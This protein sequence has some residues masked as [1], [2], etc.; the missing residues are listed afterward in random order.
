MANC[1]KPYYCNVAEAYPTDGSCDTQDYY[2][3]GWSTLALVQ[4]GTTITDPSDAV[5]MQ[6]LKDAGKL[7]IIRNIK[8]ALDEPSALTI[9]SVTSCGT[10]ITI[11]YDR[12][13]TFTDSKVSKEVVE[14]YN[15]TKKLTFGGALLVGCD[16]NTTYV[17][18]EV[19]L[20]AAT[21]GENSNAAA[22]VITAVIGWRND[23]DPVP[24]ETPADIFD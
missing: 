19:K 9:D 12:T 16:G 2:L 10:T 21:S 20:T 15:E 17:D 8:G 11:N 18:A 3:S 24:Y 4:C 5:E 1:A 7:T 14:W 6:A 22:K 23:D 13:F